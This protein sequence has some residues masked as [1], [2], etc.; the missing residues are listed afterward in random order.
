MIDHPTQMPALAQFCKVTDWPIGVF[1]KVDTG[2]H[3][4][5]VQALPDDN[6]TFCNVLRLLFSK[7]YRD[8]VRLSGLYS[9]AGHSYSKSSTP[10]C[11]EL[12]VDEMEGL[13]G[14]A[15]FVA[16]V[17][18]E[19]R[20]DCKDL[21]LTLS[22]GATPTVSTIAHHG[23]EHDYQD[24]LQL[25]INALKEDLA[26]ILPKASLEVHAGCYPF[27]DVQQIATKAGPSP[28]STLF[29][30]LSDVG[31]TILAEINSL[32][33]DRKPQEAMIAAGTL[34]IGREPC[35]SYSGWGIV[36]TWGL[37]MT[38]AVAG[39]SGWIVGRVSQE[40]GML[41]FMPKV[42]GITESV[43]SPMSLVVGAKV[44]VWPNH[45]CIA[46]A[47]FDYYV[48]VDSS[49]PVGRRNEVVDVWARCNG[50]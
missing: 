41:E 23:R 19:M 24:G 44:R 18:E 40:H 32:Y 16:D 46:G 20:R 38:E 14:A 45:A 13:I 27:L 28:S 3:R 22:V 2:Y 29:N 26:K 7:E 12:L 49:L 42:Q 4:A 17:A 8:A 5:G 10:D 34:A 48:V 36:S 43:A 39:Y 15:R 47:G 9:H 25:T 33:S 21:E 50:W 31:I 6:L 1:V 35:Q 30:T 37:G 11:M